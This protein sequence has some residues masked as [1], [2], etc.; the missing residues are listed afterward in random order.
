MKDKERI[1]RTH[2]LVMANGVIAIIATH[3]R[4]FFSENGDRMPRISTPR[5]SRFDFIDG[6]LWFT[7]KYTGKR[8]FVHYEPTV[9]CGRWRGFSQGGTLQ[10][11]VKLLRDYILNGDEGFVG[12][13][14]PWPEWMCGGDLWGYGEDME[15]VRGEVQRLLRK[16]DA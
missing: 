5:L 10:S 15:K 9:R 11:L 6:R 4:R 16:A 12:A 13:L 7:D 8:I 2:R 1:A 3:G 14:G